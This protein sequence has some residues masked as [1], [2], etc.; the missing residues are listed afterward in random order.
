MTLFFSRRAFNTRTD[1][2]TLNPAA[3]TRYVEIADPG[4][5]VRYQH[6]ISK[7]DWKAKVLAKAQTPELLVFVHG[8]NT[9]QTE[10]L[11]RQR[12]IEEGLR[13]NGYRGAV[14]G[15]DWPSDGSK[16]A[17]DKD[18]EDA[19]TVA[20]YL[21]TEGISMFLNETPR[22]KIHVLAHSMG[23][24]LA[25]RGFSGVGDAPGAR[26]WG[27]DQMLAVAADVDDEW[28]RSGAWGSL[29]MDLRAN[30]LT[31]YYSPADKVLKLS[32]FINGMRPRL[33]RAG[34]P[35]LVAAGHHDVRC[36]EQY[37]DK[38]DSA[39]RDFRYSHNWYFDD[40]GFYEDV[41]L[42]LTGKAAHQ[43]PTREDR[44]NLD[45]PILWT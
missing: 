37:F 11:R 45:D 25:T 22:M 41:A 7:S 35:D 31:N 10:M 42:T 20:P 18:R 23:V 21:V 12:K 28:M 9:D 4:V 2:F 33:G 3:L 40:D 14:I 36:A 30:R 15:Y 29:V 39:D 16:H 6:I 34:L 1:R 13:D 27:I 32:K 17:Y 26:R 44:A 8:F 43:M 38:V 5:V 24:Y 19:K